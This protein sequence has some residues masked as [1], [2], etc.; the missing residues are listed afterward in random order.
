[1][2]LSVSRF[3][4]RKIRIMP[5]PVTRATIRGVNVYLRPPRTA[6]AAVFLAAARRSRALHG[7]WMQAPVT[8]QRF[9]WLAKR[10]G[11]KGELTTHAGYLVFRCDDDALVGVFNL[12][13]IVRGAFKS[14]YLGYYAFAPLSG[15]G[16][17]TEGLALVLDIAFRKLALHRVEVNIQPDNLRSI[18]LV[19]RLGFAREGYSRRYVKIGGRWRDH[20][21]FAMLAEDWRV[22]RR[23][24][25]FP[26]RETG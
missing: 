11:A 10:F 7:Q 15:Q 17:M 24:Q 3:S 13:E 26:R 1:M 12:S 22:L 21:R 25:R 8:A 4:S 23:Q 20:V 18:G 5:T 2:E 6:D 9:A 19:E 16:L 14:A